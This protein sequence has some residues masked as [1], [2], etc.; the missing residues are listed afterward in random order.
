MDVSTAEQWSTKGRIGQKCTKPLARHAVAGCVGE[1]ST[2]DWSISVKHDAYFERQWSNQPKAL[3][4]TFQG[5]LCYL[6]ELLFQNFLSLPRCSA[7]KCRN[8]T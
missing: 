8:T 3:I 2:T 5:L 7:K 1:M 6:Q 4:I